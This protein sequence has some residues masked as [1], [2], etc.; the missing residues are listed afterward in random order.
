MKKKT[1]FK[2][3]VSVSV[4]LLLDSTD[5]QSRCAVVLRALS[6]DFWLHGEPMSVCCGKV[7]V[8]LGVWLIMSG[9][10]LL[11]SPDNTNKPQD[12]IEHGDWIITK[13]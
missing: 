2:A 11:F 8:P 3:N 13:L 10:F 6:T 1:Y 12:C 7:C 9:C 5:M 4:C